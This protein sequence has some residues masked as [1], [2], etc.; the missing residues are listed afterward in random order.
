MRKNLDRE[1]V[2]VLKQT[3]GASSQTHTHTHTPMHTPT[4]TRTHTSRHTQSVRE[5]RE[6][7]LVCESVINDFHQ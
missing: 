2:E 5:I 6:R 4:R 3:L 7:D 1:K